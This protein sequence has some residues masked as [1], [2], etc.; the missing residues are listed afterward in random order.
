MKALA[1][2]GRGGPASP[3]LVLIDEEDRSQQLTLSVQEVFVRL[4]WHHVPDSAVQALTDKGCELYQPIRFTT[5]V[6][7]ILRSAP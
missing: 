1:W 2:R 3:H 5:H 7:L 4:R 6:G